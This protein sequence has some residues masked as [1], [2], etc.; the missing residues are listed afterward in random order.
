MM[1]GLGGREIIK[2]WF[3]CEDKSWGMGGDKVMGPAQNLW[4]N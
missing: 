4:R 1:E 2:I 3:F